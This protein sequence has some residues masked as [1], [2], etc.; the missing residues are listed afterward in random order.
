[1][2]MKNLH[3]H[4]CERSTFIHMGWL[5]LVGSI[6]LWVSF[7]EYSLFHRSLLQKRPVIQSTSSRSHPIVNLLPCAVVPWGSA[8]EVTSE[9]TEMFYSEG[10][11]Q[12]S[13]EGFEEMA[14]G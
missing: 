3:V 11:S 1:M 10:N 6:K 12:G 7:A 9:L 13:R 2:Y 5:Q 14:G 8:G 4:I